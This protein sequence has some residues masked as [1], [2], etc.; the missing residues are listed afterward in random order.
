A[1]INVPEPPYNSGCAGQPKLRWQL[2]VTMRDHFWSRW[3][4]EYLQHLQQLGKWRDR[5][6]NLQPGTLVLLK[7]ELLPPGK[8]ALGRIRE[9]HPGADGLVRVVTVDTAISRLTRPITKICPLPGLR[10]A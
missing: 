7:D 6:A 5:S 2:V 8:W 10:N 4:T 9:A 3:S 1:P